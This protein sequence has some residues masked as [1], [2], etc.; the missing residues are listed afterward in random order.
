VRSLAD[1]VDGAWA[2]AGPRATTQMAYRPKHVMDLLLSG[3]SVVSHVQVHLMDRVQAR[4]SA[5]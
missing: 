5:T 1:I 2:I 3:V 4:R